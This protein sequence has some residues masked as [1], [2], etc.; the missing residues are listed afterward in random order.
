LLCCLLCSQ[1]VLVACLFVTEMGLGIGHIGIAVIALSLLFYIIGIGTTSWLV[2]SDAGINMGL[3]KVCAGGECQ[4]IP[5]GCGAG[6][7]D[8]AKWNAVRAFAVMAIMFCIF[9]LILILAAC[10]GVWSRFNT[11][12]LISGLVAIFWAVVAMC[13]FVDYKRVN[14]PGNEGFSFALW[15][16][17][18]V[19]HPLG[20]ALH[21]KGTLG[22][23]YA[24]FGDSSSSA[25]LATEST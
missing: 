5:A 19:L 3:F 16:M 17:A 9:Q 4:S 21:Y 1:A 2:Y 10:R 11:F 24:S 18:W 23:G 12:A 8:C 14:L 20:C 7:P 15:I 13:V 25:G 22:G 6:F